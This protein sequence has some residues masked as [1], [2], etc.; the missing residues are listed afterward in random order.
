[1]RLSDKFILIIILILGLVLRGIDINNNP[2]AL[3]GDELT[4]T[5]DSYS[6]LKSGQDQLG[7]PYPLTFQMG[8]GRPA[9]YV[10]V[11]IPFVA[12][13]GP[14][15]LGVRMLSILSGLGIILLLYSL[16]KRLFSEK[17]GLAVAFLTAVSPW[18][19]SLSRGG[20]EAH[21]AL[22]LAL[23]G[24]FLLMKAKEHPLLYIF[25]ALSFGATLHTYPT[26]K[27]SL[28]LFL[29]LMFWYEGGM[30][31]IIQNKY[32]SVATVTFIV[33][34]ALAFSQTFIGGSEK[35]FSDINI[36][37]Q[38]QLKDAIE[39]KINLERTIT[40][41]PPELSRYFH[42]KGVE[43]TKVFIENYLQ[44]FSMDFLVLHGDRNP[45]HNMATMGQIYFADIILMFV[46][47]LAFWGRYKKVLLFF[48]LWIILS[49]I[50]TAMIDLPHALRSSFMLL[51][52]LLLSALGLLAVLNQK[53]KILLFLIFTVFIIQFAFF[54]QKL[55]FLS[56]NEYSNFWS[57][58]ARIASEIAIE[59]K[60]KFNYILLSDKIND[61]EFAYPVYGKIDPQAVISQNKNKQLLQNLPFK[62]FDNV[63]IGYIPDEDVQKFSESLEGPV[64][65][66]GS[67]DSSKYLKNYETIIGKD[68]LPILAISKKVN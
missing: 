1:M 37:S 38:G 18:D 36:F 32:F 9:G 35:R 56:P 64:L 48:I 67:P 23:L 43:Y 49:P 68:G 45:R 58:S 44:N 8:A 15:A 62:K 54:I 22:F 65:Y 21:F 4:I 26:Y 46:G 19:I 6:L 12:I 25:S 47:L 59:N 13:F 30:K 53:K 17:A 24:L 2:P 55:Y 3:Y 57:Y 7:N 50:P 31:R 29:P 11:S 28:L 42:N 61:I 41:T 10:Y 20:F 63:Y 66:I 60:D 52:L 16:G 34:S 51:P 14:D 27:V 39:Q 40:K 33:L 5:L